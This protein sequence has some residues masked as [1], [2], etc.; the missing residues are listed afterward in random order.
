MEEA[1]PPTPARLGTLQ[2]P[3]ERTEDTRE[4]PPDVPQRPLTDPEEKI[5]EQ[6]WA[7]MMLAE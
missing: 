5:G 3:T 6:N 2:E 7:A 4:M 1:D